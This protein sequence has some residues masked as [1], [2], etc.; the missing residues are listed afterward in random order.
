MMLSLILIVSVEAFLGDVLTEA[1]FN[2]HVALDV[3]L[4]GGELL[5]PCRLVVHIDAA[6]DILNETF[7]EPIVRASHKSL[8]HLLL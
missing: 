7:E 1:L 4:D 6:D 5:L 2:G 8:L 3:E